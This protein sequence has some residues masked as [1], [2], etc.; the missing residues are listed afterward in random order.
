MRV[1]FEGEIGCYANTSSISSRIRGE[2]EVEPKAIRLYQAT[3]RE[4]CHDDKKWQKIPGDFEIKSASLVD[5]LNCG[6]VHGNCKVSEA[7]IWPV[8]CKCS[9]FMRLGT[10]KEQLKR[11]SFELVRMGNCRTEIFIPRTYYRNPHSVF[12]CWGQ[13]WRNFY[14]RM[15]ANCGIRASNCIAQIRWAKITWGWPLW[16]R[17]QAWWSVAL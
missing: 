13:N 3:Q 14:R 1:R 6:G 16:R 7:T 2:L 12:G 8:G 4:T 15:W 9:R 11:T 10:S 17:K 5:I